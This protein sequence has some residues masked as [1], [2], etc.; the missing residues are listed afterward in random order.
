M[1][2][3][4]IHENY[5]GLVGTFSRAFGVAEEEVRS[6]IRRSYA[7]HECADHG[8]IKRVLEKAER[9]EQITIAAIGGSITQGAA[10]ESVYDNNAQAFTQELG[11]EKNWVSRVADWF[12]ERFPQAKVH[13]VNAGIG[14][15]PSFLGTFRLEE[16]V[17]A[18]QPDLVTVEFS[19]NDMSTFP[20]LLE[21]EP[22]EAY[23]SVIRRCV[24]AGIAVIPIF[25]TNRDNTG[26]HACHSKIAKYYRLPSINY[27]NAVY[28][29]GERLCDWE[30]L[31][32]DEV[33]PNNAGHAF[34]A[35]CLTNYLEQVCKAQIKPAEN[36]LP[37]QWL[38][39]DTFHKVWAVYAHSL[40]NT[41][42]ESFT[43]MDD[44]DQF[45]CRLWKGVLLSNG[46]GTVQ[47]T[48]PKGAKRV[49]VQY[50]H[51][52]GSF[53]TDLNG[54]KTSCNTARIGLAR[55]MWHRVYTGSAME[56]ETV[57]TVKTRSAGQVAFTGVLVAM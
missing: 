8:A 27:H 33:H 53:E 40:K 54:Q 26:M 44:T 29:E 24:E 2:I 13:A 3:W 7:F 25:M 51:N 19:V 20:N 39:A 10:A 37:E 41:A 48:I 17:L 4:D 50:F 9:A 42:G 47:L 18:Y 52:P 34:L 12:C 22:Y 32:P 35:T 15:S 28:P 30:R 56:Q 31:S 14:A 36:Y 55:A 21:T 45:Q 23:E 1:H 5:N 6:A 38:Y 16:M 57:L 49:W 43:F 11:G 46:E